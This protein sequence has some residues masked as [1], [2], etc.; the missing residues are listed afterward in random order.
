MK[1]VFILQ[2][3]MILL[4][5]CGRETQLFHIE[6]NEE[7]YACMQEHDFTVFCYI[8]ST[9]CA[10]CSMQWLNRWVHFKSDLEKLNTNVALIVRNRNTDTVFG[11][12]SHLRL[13]FPVIFDS[14]LTI[15]RDNPEVLSQYS[16]FVV[17]NEKEVVWKGLPIENEDS[18]KG[19]RKSIRGRSWF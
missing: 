12:M 16:T 7:F 17:N 18:W 9:D 14:T 4:F 5:S 13:D 6:N 2:I 19:F 8:D 3:I 15:M 11:V 1:Q 10:P